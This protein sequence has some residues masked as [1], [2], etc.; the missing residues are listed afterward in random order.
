MMRGL[1]FLLQAFLVLRKLSREKWDVVHFH[2]FIPDGLFLGV[3]D[4]PNAKIRVMTNHSSQYLQAIAAKRSTLWRRLLTRRV[5][6]FIAPSEELRDGTGRIMTSRQVVRY[7]PNGVD[8]ERFTPGEATERA[9]EALGVGRS[10]TLVL[11]IR[12]HTPKCGLDYLL[13]AIPSVVRERPDVVF[14]LVGS[15]EETGR[16]RQIAAELE[17]EAHTRFPGIIF[18]DELP[19]ILRAAYLTV[20]PSLYEAVSLAGLESMACGVP[21]IGTR[22]GGIPAFVIDQETGLL[23]EP[24]SS[25]ALAEAVL[26][27]LRAPDLRRSMSVASRELVV[28]KFSWHSVA[29]RVMDFYAELDAA[30]RH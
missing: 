3:L 27:L 18:H 7:I 9:L 20:L 21:V 10:Q 11:S 1:L 25:H 14:C 22:V 30:P 26:T 5:R 8:L 15:G 29:E 4:W 2:N 13:R 12:R 6:G 16:L 23:V 17:V 24:R 28:Q 19:D